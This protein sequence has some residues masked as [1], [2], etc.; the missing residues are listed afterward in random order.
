M[1]ERGRKKKERSIGGEG[2]EREERKRKKEEALKLAKVQKQE[3]R[4]CKKV[5]GKDGNK[6]KATVNGARKQRK[7]LVIAFGSDSTDSFPKLMRQLVG[8][9]KQGKDPLS[10]ATCQSDS[11]ESSSHFKCQ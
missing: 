2:K 6:G 4:K 3:A 11:S 8:A 5:K 9:R 7:G 1:A 10:T